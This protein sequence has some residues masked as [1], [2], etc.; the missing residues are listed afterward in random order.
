LTMKSLE[1]FAEY[2]RNTGKADLTI[3]GYRGDLAI[4]ARWF[5]QAR[6]EEFNPQNITAMDL[7]DYRSYLLTVKGDKASTV[8]RRLV[9]IS[10]FM[11]WARAQGLTDTTPP[12]RFLVRQETELAPKWLDRKEQ[13]ALLRAVR[14]E[15]NKRDIALIELLLGTGLRLSESANLRLDDLDINPRKGWLHV[16]E[17][18]GSRPRDIPL[19]SRVRKLLDEYLAVREETKSEFV[20]QG[21]RGRLTGRGIYKVL[22]KYGYLARLDGCTP[23][24]LRHTFGK[25]L[26]DAG[27]SL[28]RV[29]HLMGHKSLDTT[30]IYTLPS[31]ADLEMDVEM[32]AV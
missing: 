5:E 24:T 2:L 11:K 21:Q 26:V 7:R 31:K 25:N 29:G 27:I 18:K 12:E 14:K 8:N 19:N 15:R 4:F 6:G 10:R 23:H 17:G 9:A 32:L 3:K 13:N 20:F 30:R 16:R 22:Q 28:D 1:R